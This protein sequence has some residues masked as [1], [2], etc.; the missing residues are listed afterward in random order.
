MQLLKR[1]TISAIIAY[2]LI[3][4]FLGSAFGQATNEREVRSGTVCIFSA[5]NISQEDATI[6]W[7]ASDGSPMSFAGRSMRWTAPVVD[8]P[9]DV[10]ISLNLTNSYGCCK[11]YEKLYSIHVVPSYFA[12]ISLKKNCL[13]TEPVKIGDRVIYTY[14]VT[15]PGT[16]PLRDLNLTD[17][18]SWGPNCQPVYMS[19]DDGNQLLDP[20]E[21]WRYECDYKIMD[22]AD[23]PTLHIM[24][25][26][27]DSAQLSR[28]IQRLMEIKARMEIVMDN[29]RLSER[30]FDMQAARLVTTKQMQRGLNYTYYNY[31]NEVTGE[32]FSR[33]VDPQGYLNKTIYQ[34]PTAGAVLTAYF[35]KY[36]KMLFIE[37]YYPPPGTNEYLKI[38]YDMPSVGYNTITVTDYKS[39]DTLILIVDGRGNVLSKEYRKTPGYQLYAEKYSLKNK[40][41]VT[42]K[43]GEGN[44]ISDWDSFALEVIRPL[45]DLLIS[46][47]AQSESTIAGSLLNYTILYKN[48]GGSDAHDIVIK[49]TYDSNLTFVRSDPPPDTGST[50]R[51]SLEALKI[52]ESGNIRV[53][54]RA[55]STVAAGTEITNKVVLTARENASAISIINTT[56]ASAD[57]NITKIASPDFALPGKNLTYTMIYRNNGSIKQNNVTIHDWLD[58]YVYLANASEQRDLIWRLGD[59]NPGEGGII[60]I[61]VVAKNAIATNVSKIVNRYRISSY[62]FAGKTKELVTALLSGK[63]NITKIASSDFVPPG[64]ELTYTI[65]YRNEGLANQTDVM[66]HDWLDPY[67]DL[68][69]VAANPPLISGGS[70]N[71]LWWYREYLNSGEE[72]TI[73]IKA[74]ANSNIPENVSQIVN[75]YRINSSQFERKN[76]T[77]KTDV[78]HSLWIRKKADKSTYNREDNITYTIYYGNY[79]KASAY[80]V[81]VTD[82]LPKVTLISVYPAPTTISGNNLTWRVGTLGENESRSIQIVVQVPKK[83]KANYYETS[84]VQG[85]GYA[86]V[87]KGFSTEDKKEGLTNLAMISGYYGVYPFKVRAN[88]SVTVLGSPGT[89]IS[90]QEHGSGYYSEETKSILH[91]ENRSISLEKSLFANYRKTSFLLPGKRRVDYDSL[92]SDRTNVENRIMSDSLEEKYLYTDTLNQNSTFAADMNQ[93]VYSSDADFRSAVAQI[94]YKKGVP[95]EEKVIQKI[96]ENYHGTF[97]LKEAVDSY[98][99]S[100]KFTKSAVGKG[101]VS[102]DKWVRGR[103]RSYESGSGYYSSQERMELGSIDKYIKMQHAPLSLRAGSQNL[104]YANLWNEGLRT[105]DEKTGAQ[106]GKDIRYASSV[107]MDAMMMESSLS[108]LGKFNG[109]LDIDTKNGPRIDL[110]QTFTGSFQIDTAIAIHDM[111]RHLYPHVNISKTASMLDEETVLFLINVSNDG[112]KLLKPLN[113]TDY[114]PEGCSYINSSIRAK[115]N[116]SMVN[117]TIPSL[118]I[119]RKLTIKMRA[120]VDGSRAIY[121]NTVSVRATSKESIVEAKNST[122]FEAFYEPLPCCPGGID[123]SIAKNKIN[124]TRLF[125]TTPT[126]GYWG[127]WS[128]SPCFNITGNITECSAESEAYYNEMEKYASLCSCASNYE[129]P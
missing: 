19:G 82:L 57:L 66:I 46:K 79:G 112:N 85:N 117:W 56:V 50:D 28:V 124:V 72:G 101:F 6:E 34:D 105:Q 129:V 121:T 80:F 40:A 24:Q 52:G 36:S 9:R 76:S 47:T 122:T 65:T 20:E 119:G 116:G 118:D 32:S 83:A 49:E 29:L 45:P 26:D 63:L 16:L 120:K 62:Q 75:T 109:T 123:S 91:Q 90:S 27:R 54:V 21:S 71:Y 89:S 10:I 59:L 111:P 33:I 14:N 78:V 84:L 35:T 95:E 106:I 114:L 8:S 108:I 5:Q 15:N 113:I 73:T 60:T 25:S 103:Q 102:S 125:N 115:T 99:E 13:F 41:T 107:D 69:D 1:R 30:Q 81:N 7:I 22:P 86:N 96:D 42:A 100:V 53:Q 88:S 37:L 97:R 11:F 68:V 55:K 18:Q 67:V 38:E 3:L 4:S 92:W 110:D 23:Y 98:G 77:L 58:P 128:P 64:R 74:K 70:G 2:A 17:L 12:Q 94:G 104:S 61:N 31:S 39:G 44:E 87:R 43:Y 93:T 48:T 126:F 127:S 51:W